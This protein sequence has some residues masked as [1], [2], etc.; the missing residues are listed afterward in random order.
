MRAAALHRGANRAAE[1]DSAGLREPQP[2]PEANPEAS[3]QGREGVARLVVVE[4]GEIVERP[5]LDRAD[6]RHARG[7][8]TGRRRFL[9]RIRS[10]LLLAAPHLV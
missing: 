5:P 7:V 8:D 4:V 9:S 2:A 3:N 6:S 1:V 10:A